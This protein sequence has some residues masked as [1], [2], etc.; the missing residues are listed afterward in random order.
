MLTIQKKRMMQYNF[1]AYLIRLCWTFSNGDL[2][3]YHI[4]DYKRSKFYLLSELK[5]EENKMIIITKRGFV[6]Q[7]VY[8]LLFPKITLILAVAT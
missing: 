6:V 5:K 4:G 2:L 3:S 1:H 7:N 8:L